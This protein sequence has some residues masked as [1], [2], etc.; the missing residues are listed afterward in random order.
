MTEIAL[1]TGSFALVFALGFQQQNIHY[2]RYVLAMVNATFIGM[3]NLA[4]L[5]LGPQAS[6]TEMLAFI[7]GEPPASSRRNGQFDQCR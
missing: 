4:M 2:R 7:T 5:K 6:P 3:L 1:F